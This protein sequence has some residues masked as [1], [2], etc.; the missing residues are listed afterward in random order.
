M[1]IVYL[2]SDEKVIISV[3]HIHANTY[4]AEALSRKLQVEGNLGHLV[5][6]AIHEYLFIKIGMLKSESVVAW[7][8]KGVYEGEILAQHIYTYIYIITLFKSESIFKKST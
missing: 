8:R 1:D 4:T 6:A 7:I 3:K 2:K 5:G